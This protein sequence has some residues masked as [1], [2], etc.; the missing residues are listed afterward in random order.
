MDL[1]DDV[2]AVRLQHVLSNDLEQREKCS[3]SQRDAINFIFNSLFFLVHIA[4]TPTAMC[5]VC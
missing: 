1:R 2:V 3:A 4:R 5:R